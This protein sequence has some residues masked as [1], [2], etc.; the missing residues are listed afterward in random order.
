MST[1]KKPHVTKLS[2]RLGV[3]ASLMLG[4][5]SLVSQVNAA[6]DAYGN[7]LSVPVVLVP[8]A[9][10]VG[11]PVLRG[12]TCGSSS[13][14]VGPTSSTFI[15][16]WIQKT[17][18]VWQAQCATSRTADVIVNWGDNLVSRPIISARQPVRVE[19]ALHQSLTDPMTGFLVEKLTPD[20]EDRYATYGTR[21]VPQS[22]ESARV[23]DSGAQLTIERVDGPGGTI[24]SGP[25]SA[26]INSAGALVYGFNWG[27]KG[28][29]QRALPGTY[30]LTFTTS[31]TRVVGVDPGDVAKATYTSRSS[32]VTI[33]LSS[34]AGR[35]GGSGSGGSGSG[36]GG[37]GLGQRR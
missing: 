28:K 9:D 17:E 1:R 27:M 12:G 35:R 36:S 22:F 33:V 5:G 14:P 10:A 31:N 4:A 29:S 21:G 11:V 13:N 3:V 32:S 16:Y 23:F 34:S 19:V 7:N 30:L 18:A 8:S 6:E 37:S 24:Y 15:G 25:M 20:V 2:L 26:E